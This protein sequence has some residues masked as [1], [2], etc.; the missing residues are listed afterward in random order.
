ML[1][2][3]PSLGRTRISLKAII[4]TMRKEKNVILIELN[5]IQF[6]DDKNVTEIPIC[7]QQLLDDQRVIFTAPTGLRSR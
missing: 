3:D 2:G 4:K 6:E 1:R 7:L 5:Q